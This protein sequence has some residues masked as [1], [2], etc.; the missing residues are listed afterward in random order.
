[1]RDDVRE[2]LFVIGAGCVALLLFVVA[3][4]SRSPTLHMEGYLDQVIVKNGWRQPHSFQTSLEPV[5]E[6]E[7]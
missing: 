1:M 2:V 6:R 3:V 4:C 7:V 5:T